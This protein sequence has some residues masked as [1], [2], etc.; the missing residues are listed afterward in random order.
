MLEKYLSDITYTHHVIHSPSVRRTINELYGSLDQPEDVRPGQIAL[1]LSILASATY[2]WTSRDAGSLFFTPEQA[3]SQSTSWI[4]AALDV[5]DY[6]R[7]KTAGSLE[8]IQAMIILSFLVS[9]LEGFSRRYRDLITTAI[10]SARLL[11]LHRID[12]PL[13]SARKAVL[14]VDSL[15][16]EIGRRVWWYLVATEW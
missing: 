12:D 4:K 6:S 11:S 8:D 2:S 9:S 13:S 14:H 16:A 7:R 15:A 5:L 1:L 3:N 10:S